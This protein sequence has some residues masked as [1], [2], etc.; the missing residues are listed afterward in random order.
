MPKYQLHVLCDDKAD[1]NPGEHMHK[2]HCGV[3]WKHT[4]ELQHDE[5]ISLDEYREAHRCPS[6]GTEQR[7]Q[8]WPRTPSEQHAM[9]ALARMLGFSK[10][11]ADGLV[12][13]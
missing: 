3:V 6:C 9:W 11:E 8:H 13:E 7:K 2:C 10:E 4:N 1:P 5:D 12:R